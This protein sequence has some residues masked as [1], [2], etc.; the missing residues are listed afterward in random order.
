MR[1]FASFLSVPLARCLPQL[2]RRLVLA[3]CIF[4][5][6]CASVGPTA[7]AAKTRLAQAQAEAR[8]LARL[9]RL[10]GR[11]A[12][13]DAQLTVL[14]EA[15]RATGK[16]TGTRPAAGAQAAK[17]LQLPGPEAGQA[18]AE[19]VWPP[20]QQIV[21][22]AS[23]RVRLVAAGAPAKAGAPGAPTVG[24]GEAPAEVA[25]PARTP[26]RVRRRF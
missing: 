24:A 7:P 13:V 23:G 12:Q 10:E 17:L 6:A 20:A 5:C 15:A 26:R 19:L 4:S 1:T 3:S 8:L 16:A 21:T 18:D 22:D 14:R 2:G 25:P 11:L 9:Q